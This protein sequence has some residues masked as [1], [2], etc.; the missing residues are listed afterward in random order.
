MAELHLVAACMVIPLKKIGP[1][2]VK[3][4]FI[5]NPIRQFL[6]LKPLPTYNPSKHGQYAEDLRDAK[7][8]DVYHTVVFY[9]TAL[10]KLDKLFIKES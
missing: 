4:H 9:L 10:A 5:I 3:E 8:I 6:G 7:F 2:C 1:F